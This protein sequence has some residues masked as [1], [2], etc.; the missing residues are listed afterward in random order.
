MPLLEASPPGVLFRIGRVPAPSAWT[1]WEYVGRGRFDDARQPPSFR[2]CYAAEQRLACFVETLAQYRPSVRL[3]DRVA[4]MPLVDGAMDEWQRAGII[5]ASWHHH[6][7]LVTMRVLPGQHWLDLRTLQ[8]R[9]ALRVLIAPSLFAL[10]L[11]DFDLGDAISRSR[12]LTQ[13]MALMIH[14]AGFHG[15]VYPSRFDRMFD[16]WAMFDRAQFEAT[17]SDPIASDDRDYVRAAHL[18]GLTFERQP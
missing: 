4:R 15:I 18:L 10:G 14:E 16:C 5:P 17:A 8:T 1:D 6:R 11:E 3:F 9:Q 13:R 7:H 12:V 2:V